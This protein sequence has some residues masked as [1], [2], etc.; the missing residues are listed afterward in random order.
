ML[1][2]TTFV[3]MTLPQDE[4]EVMLSVQAVQGSLTLYTS[5]SVPNPSEAIHDQK[6]QLSSGQRGNLLV[7]K[8]PTRQRQSITS[9]ERRQAESSDESKTTLYLSIY[10]QEPTNRFLL[11]SQKGDLSAFESSPHSGQARSSSMI[12][13][14]VIPVIVVLVNV[15]SSLF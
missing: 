2:E 6:M 4:K 13:C 15:L 7:S 5:F 12:T 11:Q 8:D 14:F 9:R 1:E 10:G 3:A